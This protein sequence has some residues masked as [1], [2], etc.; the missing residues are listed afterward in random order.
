[1]NAIRALRP[2]MR[3]LP[4]FLGAVIL[5]LGAFPAHAELP[6]EELKVGEFP[7]MSPHRAYLLSYEGGIVNRYYV[8]DGDAGDVIGVLPGGY[9]S[10]FRIAADGSAFYSS[11]TFYEK[12]TRG[13][14]LDQITVMSAKT[15]QVTQEIEI[16]AKRQLSYTVSTSFDVTEGG[17]YLLQYNMSPAGSVTVVDLQSG[18]ALPEIPS[19][20][21]GLVLPYGPTSFAMLCA[22]GS[23]LRL[24]FN[25]KGEV[26]QREQTKPFF[27]VNEDPLMQHG[28]AYP[29]EHLGLFVSYEGMI[30]E[31]D[32]KGPK[33]HLTKPW[34]VRAKGEEN[35]WPSGWPPLAYSPGKGLIYLVMH[36]G[37]KWEHTSGGHEI[38]AFDRKTHKRV[39][40]AKFEE[41]IWAIGV[42]QD[43]EPQLY[44]L[45]NENESILYIC[46]PLTGEIQ[47]QVEEIGSFPFTLVTAPASVAAQP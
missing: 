43:A 7:P 38:W 19:A 41:P 9:N 31:L 17:R 46:D 23:L 21:C 1:M 32:L 12:A 11:D 15:G 47:R 20:G 6:A 16:P 39:F 37:E 24:S 35:W 40:R 27:D 42:S 30:H 45:T 29:A 18:K 5:A 22:N 25:D 3:S 33:T 2:A 10:G 13:K 28:Y 4:T 8:V 44:A 26:T 36:E 34:S 14:R